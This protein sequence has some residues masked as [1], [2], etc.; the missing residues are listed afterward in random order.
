MILYQLITFIYIFKPPRK[1]DF[2]DNP[3]VNSTNHSKMIMS[4]TDMIFFLRLRKDFQNEV[5]LDN[6]E[7]PHFSKEKNKTT[8]LVIYIFTSSW[9]LK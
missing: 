1:E 8:I 9:K 7:G 6:I 3:L 4:D 5:I 2:S